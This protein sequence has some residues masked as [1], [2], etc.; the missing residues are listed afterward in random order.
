MH[1]PYT[2]CLSKD[3]TFLAVANYTVGI[4]TGD[5]TQSSVC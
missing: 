2:L 5:L 1:D 4:E 3:K